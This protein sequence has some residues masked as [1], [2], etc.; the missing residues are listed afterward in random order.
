[1]LEPTTFS[2][3]LPVHT[4]TLPGWVSFRGSTQ[5][6]DDSN[7]SAS[8]SAATSICYLRRMLIHGARAVLLRVK[9]NTGGLGQWVNRLEERAPAIYILRRRKA[10]KIPV[11]SIAGVGGHPGM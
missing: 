9:Y 8:V 2:R 1:M 5:L 11:S 3:T 6:E 4:E 10:R 7:C